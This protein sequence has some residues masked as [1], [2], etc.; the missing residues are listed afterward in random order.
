[1]ITRR[2][3]GKLTLAGLAVPRYLTAADPTVN[4]VRIGTQTYSFRDLPRAPGS[5][6][7][8]VIIKSM[9]ECGL[10]ECELFAPQVEP[11]STAGRGQ[12]GAPP[13]PA[14]VKDREELRQWRLETSLDHFRGIKQKF[15]AAG[16]TIYAYN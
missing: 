9:T 3:F 1:M 13:S 12:R 11:R 8:D 14:A 4:G 15:D 2:E 10:S 5:D 6:H 16:I 7:V